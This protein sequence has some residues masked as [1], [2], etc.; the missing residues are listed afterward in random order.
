M[1]NEAFQNH[2]L[3]DTN[4]PTINPMG[5][6]VLEAKQSTNDSAHLRCYTYSNYAQRMLD[7]GRVDANEVIRLSQAL[8]LSIEDVQQ[9]LL[10]HT[11]EHHDAEFK[12]SAAL[13][14]VRTLLMLALM[15]YDLSHLP[16]QTSLHSVTQ[17]I[18]ALADGATLFALKTA[19]ESLSLIHGV[20]L[21]EST[22][23][24]MPLWI[25][26]MGKLSGQELNVSSDIDLVFV[27]EH[28][29]ETQKDE[30]HAVDVRI[31]PLSHSEF[32][33]RVGR[34][35]IKLLDDVTEFGF[36]FRVDMRLRPN[37]ASGALCVSLNT[38][39]KY[40]FTQARTW[41]RFVWLKSR[42]MNPD[43]VSH[44]LLDM[45]TPFVFRRYLDYDAID[46]LRDVHQKIRAKAMN[47]SL[48]HPDTEDIKI[49][50]GGIREIE[51]S[52]QLPQ[53]I[54]GARSPKLQQKSTLSI[55]PELVETGL[56]DA[57]T[58]AQLH[59]HYVFLRHLEH[60]IQYLHDAQTQMIPKSLDE[61]FRIALAMG[62][63]DYTQLEQQLRAG[64][65]QVSSHF[66]TLFETAGDP[67]AEPT[68]ADDPQNDDHA[69]VWQYF[70]APQEAQEAH[71]Q[72]ESNPRLALLPE[73]SLVRYKQL[74][75]SSAH[76]LVQSH[77]NNERLEP[78]PVEWLRRVWNF[79]DAV[80]RRSSYLALL[81]EYPRAMDRLVELLIRSR[82]AASYLTTHPI[83][84]DELLNIE[85]LHSAPDW[86][87]VKQHLYELLAHAAPDVERQ[88]DV[89]REV[90]HSQVFRLLAQELDGLWQVEQ[91]AD[92][93][94]DLTDLI[95]Q[96]AMHFCW[97]AFNKKHCP[98]PK[99]AIIAYGKLGGKEM[100]YASDLDL[101]FIYDDADQEAG[102]IY[103]RFAQRLD[104]WLT[105]PTGAGRL[106]ET[107][108]R[109]RP[110]GDSGLM[111]VSTQMFEQYQ[112]Q[113]A[114]FWEHQAL[115]RARFC[116]GDAAV[117]AWFETCR[118]SLLTQT[119]D[120]SLVQNEILDMRTKLQAGHPN[121]TDL[122][123]LKYDSGGMVDLEFC[124]QALVLIY[125]NKHHQLIENK[126]NIALLKYAESAQL[127]SQGLGTACGDAYR[128]YRHVQHMARLQNV[129]KVRVAPTTVQTHIDAVNQ[130]RIEVLGR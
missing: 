63:E 44:A 88:M 123:D 102:M 95:L 114:W 93:L 67:Q 73:R 119:R 23:Q 90:H 107:D 100:G 106:F 30:R 54:K 87:G 124:V 17:T 126:G 59:A 128:A 16:T 28:E 19:Y 20:P 121:P 83:L 42:L 113:S 65:N 43:A 91:L 36:V 15:E 125:S 130:L 79:L 51:F 50:I 109:L 70:D 85:Q 103:A 25:F 120:A 7:G 108:Y 56:M 66:N 47:R 3:Q 64:Q 38:L 24:P 104:N 1:S 86:H 39:E 72:A 105:A 40:L 26:G 29:G 98:E 11:P 10:R 34:R 58:S 55:L 37:G 99:L 116:A 60:R 41:E 82:W 122:F 52:A 35:V 112:I 75:L 18:S 115:T 71:A 31:R 62:Y 80:S 4:T 57:T 22:G 6:A 49:G 33:D 94:S 9:L 32:F 48:K 45:I 8:P 74:L 97:Q 2:L 69:Q 13:R 76:S 129:D 81:S 127:I 53:I 77:R 12:A 101:V 118:S 46:A 84:L 96:A 89:L 21:S 61:R 14:Q 78:I 110:N 5:T 68:R 92:H 111:V 27:F 117:G